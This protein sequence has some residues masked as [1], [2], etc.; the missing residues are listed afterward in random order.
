[1]DALQL[2]Q[3]VRTDI[4]ASRYFCGVWAADELHRFKFPPHRKA[5]LIVNFSSRGYAGSHW[6]S[7]AW[8]PKKEQVLYMDP[9]GINPSLHPDIL[10]F[11]L[12]HTIKSR[13]TV[14]AHNIQHPGTSTCGWFCLCWVYCF[15]RHWS[16]KRFS[17]LFTRDTKRNED[18]IRRWSLLWK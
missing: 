11:I 15:A 3:L 8:L 6:V 17:S 10:H 18:T 1:M 7:I 2:E 14:L 12:K 9:A 13:C 4:H 16:L 5:V